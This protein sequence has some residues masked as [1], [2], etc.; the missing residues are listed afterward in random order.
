MEMGI[1]SHNDDFYKYSSKIE[2]AFVELN[3][4]P[5]R[6]KGMKQLR[7]LAVKSKKIIFLVL[8]TSLVWQQSPNLAMGVMSEYEAGKAAEVAGIAARTECVKKSM[9]AFGPELTSLVAIRNSIHYE[10]NEAVENRYLQLNSL[11]EN[12]YRDGYQSFLQKW[13]S[14]KSTA[15]PTATPTASP[16]PKAIATKQ[17]IEAPP[18]KGV[19]A[20]ATGKSNSEQLLEAVETARLANQSIADSRL[21]IANVLLIY[22]ET[23]QKLKAFI[24]SNSADINKILGD[25]ERRAAYSKELKNFQRLSLENKKNIDTAIRSHA[26]LV[27]RQLPVLKE[28]LGLIYELPLYSVG[29]TPTQYFLD[30]VRADAKDYWSKKSDIPLRME[31]LE[32][33]QSWDKTKNLYAS[34]DETLVQSILT[35]DQI[36][37]KFATA[38]A[39]KADISKV[40]ASKVESAKVKAEETPAAEEETEEPYATLAVSKKSKIKYQLTISSNFY[41]EVLKISATRKGYKTISFKV[42][43]NDSGKASIT[44]TQNLS[45]FTLK[46]AYDDADGNT[47]VLDTVKVK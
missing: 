16:T 11:C 38:K 12:S 10:R 24:S 7:F 39:S 15:T 34:S 35:S 47:Y 43:T 20:N 23:N 29:G 28:M 26:E 5:V 9:E 41:E 6:L 32:Y 19:S 18:V 4:G 33:Q 8:M 36:D 25:N 44:R 13:I 21:V 37:Q 46:V 45:G 27:T 30:L 40:E 42:K 2:F 1:P 31:I 17:I 22:A 3:M 14:E